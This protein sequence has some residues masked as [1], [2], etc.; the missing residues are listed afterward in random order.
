MLWFF[1]K[2]V[3]AGFISVCGKTLYQTP[4]KIIIFVFTIAVCAFSC[5]Q[6][7]INLTDEELHTIDS[8]LVDDVPEG[9]PGLAIGIVRNKY[10]GFASLEDSSLISP[11]T[12]FNIASNG[13]QFT[14]L[15]ALKLMEQHE[16]DPDD[17]IR[18]TSLISIRK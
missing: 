16:M 2:I 13:K 7:D 10:S 14:A 9:A 18:N 5:T 17:D 1:E 15:A 8:I 4:M 3:I 6:H 12:R 11:E